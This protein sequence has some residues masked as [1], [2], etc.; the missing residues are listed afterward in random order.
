M[1]PERMQTIEVSLVITLAYSWRY[2]WEGLSYQRCSLLCCH[3]HQ[4]SFRSLKQ[5][6]LSEQSYGEEETIPE[7]NYKYVKE[8]LWIFAEY[9]RVR[10]NSMKLE[11]RLRNNVKNAPQNSGRNDITY[12]TPARG[13]E[14]LWIIFSIQ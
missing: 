3:E 14:S 11:N 12:F 4:A 8:F 9:A 6:I 5:L 10:W 2:R 13:E 7:N 1:I